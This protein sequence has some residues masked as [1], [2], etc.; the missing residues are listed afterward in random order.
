MGVQQSSHWK[1]I[2]DK[3]RKKIKEVIKFVGYKWIL[4]LVYKWYASKPTDEKLVLFA[5]QRNRKM[6]DNFI[7]LYDMCLE[8]G[9]H[10]EVMSGRSFANNAVPKWARRKEKLKFHLQF[11]KLFAECRALFLVDWFPLAY[12]VQPRQ[13]T[14]VVQL[15]HACG[16]MKMFGYST[17]DKAWNGPRKGKELYPSHNTYTLACVSGE[18]TVKPFEDGFGC[19]EGIVK[20]IGCPRTDIYFDKTAMAAA[21]EKVRQ[22][23]PEIGERKIILYAPTFR[24]NSIAKANMKLEFCFRELLPEISDQYVMFVKLHPQV[25]KANGISEIDRISCLGSLFD[26]SRTLTAE[27]ALCAAD[28]LITDYSSIMFEYLLME[29]PIISY[30]YDIDK[31]IKDR[32]LYFPYEQLAPGPYVF[33][34]EALMDKIKTVSEWFD[35]EKVRKLKEEF[36]SACDG[37]STERIFNYV[38]GNGKDEGEIAE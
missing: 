10:C 26:V 8:K 3:V 37:H 32:G 5:D 17:A 36:M 35:V 24:G 13:E 12:I 15:W 34:Q 29:R 22:L 21:S 23:Y 6:P 4:P 7:R 14:A 2:R 9:Y 38:F 31:Y 11:I 19:G 1:K 16:A 30:I 25:M 18:K 28:I 27:E 33:S 20:A